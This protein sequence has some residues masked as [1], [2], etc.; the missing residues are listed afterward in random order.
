MGTA[1][2]Q[3]MRQ[4]GIGKYITPFASERRCI[5]RQHGIKHSGSPRTQAAPAMDII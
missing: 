5:T 3:D 1:Q 2:C 4:P